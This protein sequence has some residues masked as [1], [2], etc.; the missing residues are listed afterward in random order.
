MSSSFERL[1]PDLISLG[2]AFYGEESH[3]TADPE[4]T[5][6]K[7][8]PFF[9]ED[10]KAFRMLLAWMIHASGMIHIERLTA[11]AKDR[12]DPA[13]TPILGALAAKLAKS[14]RRWKTAYERYKSI[15]KK[16]PIRLTAPEGYTDQFMIEKHGLDPEF[17]EFGLK[18]ARILPEDRKKILTCQGIIKGNKWL[19]FRAWIG[20]NFRA[21]LLFLVSEKLVTNPFQA[22][23]QLGCSY[24]TTHRL[25]K[26]VELLTGAE[27]VGLI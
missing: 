20:P 16:K 18:I 27:R 4:R 15:Q 2:F 17:G 7:T 26:Q 8:I 22:A 23:K 1:K 3:Q 6:L 11:L 5:I 25:W 10:M 21:D 19:R 12:L 24:Q 13:L 14:D 9:Y